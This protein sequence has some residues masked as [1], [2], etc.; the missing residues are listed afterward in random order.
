MFRLLFPKKGFLSLKIHECN[1]PELTY[2]CRAAASG[3]D[4]PNNS[5]S[6]G[7]TQKLLSGIALGVISYD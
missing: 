7:S 6:G 4:R 1:R 3:K 2:K 5:P